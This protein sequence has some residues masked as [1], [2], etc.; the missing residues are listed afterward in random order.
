[1][2][3]TGNHDTELLGVVARDDGVRHGVAVDVGSGGGG[4][5][6]V[7]DLGRGAFREGAAAVLRHAHCDVGQRWVLVHVL[8]GDGDG[9]RAHL[10]WRTIV[11]R[12]DLQRVRVGCL[13]VQADTRFQ[14][15]VA[16]HG[17]DGEQRLGSAASQRVRHTVAVHVSESHR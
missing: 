14:R 1:M 13:V 12:G 11:C 3:A 6:V 16:R 4:A 2:A 17:V 8:D 15:D 10:L 9:F 5:H 7:A